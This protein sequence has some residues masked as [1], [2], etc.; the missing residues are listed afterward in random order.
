MKL[1]HKIWNRSRLVIADFRFLQYITR[2]GTHLEASNR[3]VPPRTQVA[4]LNS[5]TLCFI[6]APVMMLTVCY[7]RKNNTNDRSEV[8]DGP[9]CSEVAS[10]GSPSLL[11]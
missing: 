8:T 9:S 1:Y 2:A 4:I 10:M 6:R 11:S 7:V 5:Y 3:L